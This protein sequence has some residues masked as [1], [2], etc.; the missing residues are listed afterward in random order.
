MSEATEDSYP[1]D[2]VNRVQRRQDRGFY[3]HA[4]VAEVPA[5][6]VL[7]LSTQALSIANE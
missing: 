5:Q 4:T 7:T 6:P 3:D 1:V 2:G